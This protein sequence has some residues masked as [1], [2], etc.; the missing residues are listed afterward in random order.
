MTKDMNSR[1]VKD[2]MTKSVVSV[3]P[4]D[5]VSEAITI[6]ADY[7][8]T[9]LPITDKKSRCVGILSTTDL[10]D[11]QRWQKEGTLD[12]PNVNF[13]DRRVG[14]VMTSEVESVNRETP[15]V[16]ATGTML[17]QRVH[18]LPV[19]DENQQLLGIIST[20]DLLAAFH[21]AHDP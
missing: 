19:V 13:D 12:E 9:V 8:V 11:P 20:L 6:M 5:S 17:R 14:D 15:L 4:D 21:K 7:R 10:V 18:H 3:S 2:E 1:R 16:K